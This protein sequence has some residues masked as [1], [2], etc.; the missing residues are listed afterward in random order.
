M[1]QFDQEVQAGQRFKFGSNWTLFLQQ[2]NEDRIRAAEQSLRDM[3][4]R[5]DLRGLSFLDIGNGSGL[6]S[7]AARRLGARV[8]SF[9]FDPR[10]VA[11]AQE[12]RRRY[13]PDDTSWTVEEGSALDAAYLRS[14]GQFDIVYSWGVL[15][16]TGAMWQA[17][18]NAALPVAPSGRLFIAI[19][20]DQG[21]PSRRW[22]IVKKLYNKLPAPLAWLLA[23][24]VLVHQWWRPIVK[25]FIKLQPFASWREYGRLRGMT[26]WRDVVDWTGGYPF[27][28][29]KPEQL[30]DFYQARGFSLSRLITCGG[31][32]GCN[33]LVFVRN[34]EALP[35]S[36]APAQTAYATPEPTHA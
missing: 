9:D 7:L 21:T 12:L 30:F 34:G 22:T 13:Y 11:C 23:V 35:A 10:S 15:H 8:H 27:E 29:A 14:L 25:D 26:P 31:S 3:L 18:A 1:K 36:T 32:M 28:V 6:F 24:G 4:Q 20:N 19:Y 33:E 17:L 2:L 16:H 5:K